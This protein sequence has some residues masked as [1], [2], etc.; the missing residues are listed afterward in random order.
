MLMSYS[1]HE[2]IFFIEPLVPGPNH[3]KSIGQRRGF[4]VSYKGTPAVNSVT[5]CERV[6]F[7]SGFRSDQMLD[8]GEQ[9]ITHS[10][11]VDKTRIMIMIMTMARDVWN[12]IVQI[13]NNNK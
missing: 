10:N 6:H 4:S 3:T 1:I 11:P 7:R 2:T 5:L 13:L 8:S 9:A 12:T